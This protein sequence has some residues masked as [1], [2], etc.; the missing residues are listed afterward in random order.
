[1]YGMTAER[2][3]AGEICIDM[4]IPQHEFV[5]IVREANG[6]VHLQQGQ[7]NQSLPMDLQSLAC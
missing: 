7:H 1:M 5:M 3:Q 4:L 6:V 2:I